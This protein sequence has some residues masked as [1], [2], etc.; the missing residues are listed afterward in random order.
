MGGDGDDVRS[1]T[2]PVRDGRVIRDTRS[3]AAQSPSTV[4][5]SPATA[6]R[7]VSHLCAVAEEFDQQ[8]VLRV[9]PVLGLIPDECAI[10]LQNRVR[11]LLAAVGGQAV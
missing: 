11:D 8:G 10:R 7:P 4:S 9:H 5:P 2:R 6:L 1:R 3:T